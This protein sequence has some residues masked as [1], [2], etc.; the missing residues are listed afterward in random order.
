MPENLQ[1]VVHGACFLFIAT[2]IF[3]I[4]LSRLSLSLKIS[5]TSETVKKKKQ[6]FF[7]DTENILIT[8]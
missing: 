3:D 4:S 7:S 6:N 5:P 8:D 1:F 2:L